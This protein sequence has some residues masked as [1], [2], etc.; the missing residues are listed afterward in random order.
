MVS[1]SETNSTKVDTIM[2]AA[3]RDETGAEYIEMDSKQRV[4]L[5]REAFDIQ[6]E[7]HDLTERLNK[8]LS[9]IIHGA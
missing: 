1:I 6:E 9:K 3:T 7:I 5:A 4:D 8:I 2:N